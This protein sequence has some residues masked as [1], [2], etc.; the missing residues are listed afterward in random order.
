MLGPEANES[1]LRR[2]SHERM[3]DL[4][5]E[6]WEDP[7]AYLDSFVQGKIRLNDQCPRNQAGRLDGEVPA[8][9]RLSGENIRKEHCYFENNDGKVTLTSLQDSVTVRVLYYV[10]CGILLFTK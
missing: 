3:L 9:I 4:P 8:V 1:S 5:A 7:C 6:A 2:P 10:F